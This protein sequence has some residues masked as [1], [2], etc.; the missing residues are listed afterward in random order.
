M[1]SSIDPK[2]LDIPVGSQVVTLEGKT[3]FHLKMTYLD[4]ETK[5]MMKRTWF[6][7]H[8]FGLGSSWNPKQQFKNGCLV[9]QPFP[10]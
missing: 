3:W 1:S 8:V 5:K 2:Y 4:M 7:T 10:M 6:Q 9:K